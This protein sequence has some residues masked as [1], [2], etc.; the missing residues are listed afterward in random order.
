MMLR[1]HEI[2]DRRLSEPFDRV[3]PIS[4]MDPTGCFMMC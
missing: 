3:A 1:K 2:S 4:F